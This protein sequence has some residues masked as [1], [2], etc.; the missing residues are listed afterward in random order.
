[1][2]RLFVA[3]GLLLAS[4]LAAAGTLEVYKSPTC[5]CCEKWSQHMRDNGFDVTTHD[6]NN[7]QS[8]KERARLRPGMGSCHTAFIDGYA[9]EGHV[10]AEDVKRLLQQ[11][12]DAYGLTVPAMPVGS[13]GM[14][15]GGRQDDYQVLLY[16]QDGVRV[17]ATH[18]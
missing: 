1:M 12:P 14:E 6:V 10:P 15:M 16:G 11:K 8:V 18:P 4:A 13:P 9:I 3:A 5:S 17:F 2:Y 7:L